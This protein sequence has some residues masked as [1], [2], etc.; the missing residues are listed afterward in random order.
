MDVYC[1]FRETS[2][3]TA[4]MSRDPPSFS[5]SLQTPPLIP[6]AISRYPQLTVRLRDTVTL[7]VLSPN[8]PAESQS[9]LVA[10]SSS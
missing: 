8:R 7:H 2:L 6:I 4:I 10:S 3:S 1:V 9:V 5:L